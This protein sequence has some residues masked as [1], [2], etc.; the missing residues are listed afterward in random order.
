M[1]GAGSYHGNKSIG[2]GDADQHIAAVAAIH[3][4]AQPGR[5]DLRGKF[6]FLTGRVAA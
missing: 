3:D 1:Q 4:D 2:S 6:G 5:S